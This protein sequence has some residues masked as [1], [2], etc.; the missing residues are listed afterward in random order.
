MFCFPNERLRGVN[1]PLTFP[2][3]CV[4]KEKNQINFIFLKTM[5]HDLLVQ[6]AYNSQICHTGDDGTTIKQ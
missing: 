6:M 1:A 5:S 2:K 4:F 3:L